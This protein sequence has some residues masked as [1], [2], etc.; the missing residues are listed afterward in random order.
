[1]GE[2]VSILIGKPRWRLLI[3]LFSFLVFLAP[4]Q[5]T[6]TAH[7][8]TAGLVAAYAF[9][10]GGGTTARDASGN[11]NSGLVGTATWTSASKYAA[12][13]PSTGR[14]PASW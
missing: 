12:L 4:P 6:T 10:E 8:A 11:G 13:W 5:A 7:G 14:A 1:M 9:D 3:L 2:L